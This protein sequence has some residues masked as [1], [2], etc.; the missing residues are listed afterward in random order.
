MKI[1]SCVGTRPNFVKL[2]AITNE[3][4]KEKYSGVI[5]HRICHTN[6]HFKFNMSTSFFEQLEIPIPNWYLENHQQNRSHQIGSMIM[7]FSGILCRERPD[8]VMIYGD[9]DSTLACGLAAYELN[10][11]VAHV[12][13][14]L[15]SGDLTMPEEMN[16]I[17]SDRFSDFLFVS[18]ASGVLNLTKEGINKSRIYFVGNVMIDTLLRELKKCKPLNPLPKN[19][20]DLKTNDYILLTLHRPSNVD[21]PLKLKI[22]LEL[23]SK[24]SQ[25]IRI[26]FPV[27]PRT[28]KIIDQIKSELDL[29]KIILIDPLPYLEFIN[30]LRNAALMITDSGGIQEESTYLGIQCITARESTERPATITDG[31]NHLAGSNFSDVVSKANEILRGHLKRGGIPFLWDGRSAE[32]IFE[33][34]INK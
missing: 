5:D 22:I 31:T 28:Q 23:L 12:E 10:I 30:L 29:S 33:I 3:L 17:L 2:A 4:K 19:L 1:I 20:E 15:R 11:K 21:D 32:R 24:L 27:H 13:S 25:R 18:E 6:Q 8:L 7:Q 26:V 9:V 16:R 14:G 34:I